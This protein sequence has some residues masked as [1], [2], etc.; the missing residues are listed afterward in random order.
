MLSQLDNSS[1]RRTDL[2]PIAY[3]NGAFVPLSEAKVSVLDR[4]FLFADGIYEVSAVLDGKLVDND[5]HLARL[6]R[7]VG[8]I[9]LR[10]TETIARMQE[11]QRELIDRNQLKDGLVY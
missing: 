3:V 1:P 9:K 6:E 2:D 5:S 11:V 4:G 10:L 8:E 7:S